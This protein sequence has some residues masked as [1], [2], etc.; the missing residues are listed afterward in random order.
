MLLYKPFFKQINRPIFWAISMALIY[1]AV[2]LYITIHLLHD[3]YNTNAF[4]LGI[5]TQVLN[6]TL[7]GKIFY[8][9]AGGNQFAHHFSPI[10]FLLVPVYWLFPY[11]QTLLVVQGLILAFGG[12][13]V[14]VIA[15]DYNFSEGNSLILEGLYFLNPLVWGVALWDFHEVVFSIPALLLMFIGLK[16]KNWI[17]FGL[18]LFLAL[19]T[20]EDVVLA[21]GCFGFILVILDYRQHQR[22]EKTSMIILGSAIFAYGMGVM[23][24]KLDSGAE[25]ARMLSY[26]TNRYEYTA[27]PLQEA[28][29]MAFG[30]VISMGSLFLV[31]AYLAPFAF[32]PLLSLRWCIPALLIMLSG[33]LSTHYGQHSE[34]MQYPAAAIPFLFV[35]FM[36]VLPKVRENQQIKSI[37]KKMENRTVGYA[38]VL[39]IL[40]SVGIIA[41]GRIHL[42]ALPDKHDAALNQVISSIPDNSTVTAN[43]VVFPH[44]CSRTETY[45]FAEEGKGIAPAAGIS[46]G[47]W[48]FSDKDTEYVVVDLK[49]NPYLIP[50]IK[51]ISEKYEQIMS[52]DGVSLYQL[53]SFSFQ[54]S[55][56]SFKEETIGGMANATILFL[57]RHWSLAYLCPVR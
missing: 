3:S 26:F 30:T 29:P 1:A 41:D 54:T 19:A 16:R 48:G 6:N 46:K 31:G 17:F 56:C 20:K 11:A 45:L 7:H 47:N 55:G 53:K 51:T 25:S 36:E 37:F 4:D 28:I 39:I 32:L 52:V 21:L 14:Y 33:I 44:L 40:I 42:I 50:K 8:S 27:F 2:M 34:L 38:V 12:Y 22:I 5:F 10:L 43:N 24:S 23:I 49:K 13:L 35:S 18:G 9:T 15:R 57:T